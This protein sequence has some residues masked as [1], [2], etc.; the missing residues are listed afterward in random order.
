MGDSA[1]EMVRALMLSP[2]LYAVIVALT[3]LD[4]FVPLVP[5]ETAVLVA[6]TFAAAQ[7]PGP[8]LALVVAA[9]AVGAVVGDHVA[10]AVGRGVGAR[11]LG[12]AAP[13]GRVAR[14]HAWAGEAA[15]R[16]GGPVLVGARFVPGGRTATTMAM[17]ATAFPLRRFLPYDALAGLLWAL[18]CAG[19]GFVGGSVLEDHPFLAAAAGTALAALV[20][21]AAELVRRRVAAR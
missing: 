6:G 4:A 15:A 11:L 8:Q 10:Y 13:G 2:W 16:G 14:A 1:L 18:W 5:S 17:G 7:G 9:G 21:S 19:L 3:V 20:G 12:R